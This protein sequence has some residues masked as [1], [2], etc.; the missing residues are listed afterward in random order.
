MTNYKFSG[1]ETFPCRYAWLPKAYRAI[2]DQHDAFA[3]EE[4]AM[5]TLGV[6]KNMVRAIRFWMQA[7][8]IVEPREGGGYT[9]TELG[10]AILDPAGFDPFLEDKQTLWL[11]HWN[12]STIIDEPLFAWDYL[13]NR[14]P[15]PEI[16]RAEVKRVFE[17]ESKALGRRLSPVTLEQHFDVFLHTYVPT[18]SR[19]G[20]VQE[21]NLDCPLVELQLIQRIGERELGG[22]RR[23]PLYAF[24]REEKPEITPKLF[25]Y[26]LKDFWMCRKATEKTLTLR[27]VA[28][29]HGSPGQV[30]K[31][32]EWDIRERLEAIDD[33]SGGEFYYHE[34]AAEPQVR[35]REKRELFGRDFLAPIY[36]RELTHA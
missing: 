29:A 35:R 10:C 1:H 30:F 18:R 25:A 23:E 24:R 11:I 34:S 16:S 5:V 27:E 36:E 17:Q 8:R 20:S 33:A 26:C 4:D 2:A 22:G 3:D 7:A 13:L 21:D 28:V 19:K 31:L 6:G 32:P 15:H 9:P 14:W 12:I